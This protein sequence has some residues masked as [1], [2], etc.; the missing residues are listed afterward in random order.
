DVLRQ[1]EDIRC[2]AVAD[3]ERDDLVDLVPSGSVVGAA[4]L[5]EL[6]PEGVDDGFDELG[7]Q[8]TGVHP[9]QLGRVRGV[10]IEVEAELVRGGVLVP[11]T[12]ARLHGTGAETGRHQR[13]GAEDGTS[14]EGRTG[15]VVGHGCLLASL[16]IAAG[17]ALRGS[18]VVVFRLT[19]TYD[20]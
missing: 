15:I 18:P 17:V 2:G 3:P 4:D 20:V 19:M 5:R 13:G 10:G 14:A 9:C 7:L 1:G 12:C 8:V 16:S 6:L 11:G